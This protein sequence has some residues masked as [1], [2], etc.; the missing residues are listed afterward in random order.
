MT[1]TT[2]LFGTEVPTSTI[3]FEWTLGLELEFGGCV[4]FAGDNSR[5][6]YQSEASRGIV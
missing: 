6:V 5:R 4:G 2:R 1:S 3:G